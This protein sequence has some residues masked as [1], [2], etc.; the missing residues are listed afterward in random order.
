MS[1]NPDHRGSLSV[2]HACKCIMAGWLFVIGLLVRPADGQGQ[3]EFIAG[4]PTVLKHPH[5]NKS[6]GNPVHCLTFFNEGA[7]L[8]TGATSGVLVWDV[9]SGELRHTLDLDERAVDALTHDSRGTLLIAGGASGIIKVWDSRTFKPIRTLGPT[10]GAGGVG[11][12]FARW[13]VPAQW[14]HGRDG[15]RMG[16]L[17]GAPLA[18]A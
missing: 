12:L 14:R 3:V 5:I 2:A 7:W 11:E 16:S 9:G 8:A 1:Y 10:P 4:E 13:Q 18:R 6:V 17:I 15:L